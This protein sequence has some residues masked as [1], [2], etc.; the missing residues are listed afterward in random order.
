M[1]DLDYEDFKRTVLKSLLRMLEGRLQD[2]QRM[3]EF[4]GRLDK[5]ILD[6]MND[7]HRYKKLLEELNG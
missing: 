6:T 3:K 7:I 1:D 4:N 5:E 2:L